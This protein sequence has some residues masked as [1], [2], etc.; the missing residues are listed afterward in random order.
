MNCDNK[1]IAIKYLI[2]KPVGLFHRLS[3]CFTGKA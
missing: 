2:Y 3:S 1:Y